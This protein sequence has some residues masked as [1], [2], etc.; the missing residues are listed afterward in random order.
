M[1]DGRVGPSRFHMTPQRWLPTLLGLVVAEATAAS[2]GRWVAISVRNTPDL[3]KDGTTRLAAW[4]FVPWSP[5]YVVE[6]DDLSTRMSLAE[7]DRA[8][9]SHGPDSR[10]SVDLY[11][12]LTREAPTNI[13]G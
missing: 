8:A 13:H 3:V 6:V 1:F 10:Q 5:S 12:D 11:A 7:R 9:M 2:P 4:P